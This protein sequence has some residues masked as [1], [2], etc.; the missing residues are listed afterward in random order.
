MSK[1]ELIETMLPLPWYTSNFPN[2][3]GDIHSLNYRSYLIVYAQHVSLM[4][5]LLYWNTQFYILIT[6]VKKYGLM[7]RNGKIKTTISL[8]FFKNLQKDTCV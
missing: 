5:I 3:Y 2:H 6:T 1:S 7:C 4:S 8:F